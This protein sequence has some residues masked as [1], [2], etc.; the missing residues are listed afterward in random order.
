M[1]DFD[2]DERGRSATAALRDAVFTRSDPDGPS[3]PDAASGP[4]SPFSQK[5]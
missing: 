5:P 4:P 1:N 3:A 2:L